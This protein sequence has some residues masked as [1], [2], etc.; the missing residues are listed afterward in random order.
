MDTYNILTEPWMAVIDEQGKEISVGLRDFLV[1]AHKYK[2]SAENRNL[3]IVRRLQQRLAETIIMDIFGTDTDTLEE[4]MDVGC[5]DSEIVDSYFKECEQEGVSFDLFNKE[6]PFMQADRIS[7]E[8]ILSKKEKKDSTTVGAINPR[9]CS[10]NNKVF[11]NPVSIEDYLNNTG[12]ED[13]RFSFY[14]NVYDS[15]YVCETANRVSFSEYMNLLLIVHCISGIGGQG[16][17]AGLICTENRPPILYH[18]DPRND[19]NLFLSILM[20]I[21]F[22]D[23]HNNEKDRPM[24]R[25]ETYEDGSRFLK[26][27]G[28]LLPKKMGMFFPVQYI[29]PD[30]NSIDLKDRTISRIY[31]IGMT[32]ARKDIFDKAREKWI[33]ETEPSVSTYM[34]TA[35]KKDDDGNK[36][37][38]SFKTTTAFSESNRAWLDIKSYSNIYDGNAPKSLS[39]LTPFYEKGIK[40]VMTAYYV[41]MKQA[42][43]LTQGRLNCYL[44]S[45]VLADNEKNEVSKAFIEHIIR[46]GT[47]LS[48]GISDILKNLYPNAKKISSVEQVVNNRFMRYCEGIYKKQFIPRLSMIDTVSDNHASEIEKLSKEFFSIVSRYSYRQIHELP[49]PYGKSIEAEKLFFNKIK[50]WKKEDEK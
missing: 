39:V 33:S 31:K 6:R 14:D 25:W 27:E 21:A 43:Y 36:V 3:S 30:L 46:C 1:N 41:S 7:F 29:Y 23:S 42:N 40:P 49:I 22:D 11:F 24:W 16:Y 17:A 48:K 38:V 35:N 19:E 37:S 8:K 12:A 47:R 15:K 28:I 18:I 9:M 13:N 50:N 34:V 20:N 26:N 32:V 2:K 5:F 10:G 45:C 4:L 44:P